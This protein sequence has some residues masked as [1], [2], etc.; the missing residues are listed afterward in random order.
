MLNLRLSPAP[1]LN[2]PPNVMKIKRGQFSTSL[3]LYSLH[4][5]KRTVRGF[6]IT[7]AGRGLYYSRRNLK[8]KR[9]IFL[10]SEI[11]TSLSSFCTFDWDNGQHCFW[12]PL[13]FYVL[14]IHAAWCEVNDV[15]ERISASIFGIVLEEDYPKYWDT[16]LWNMRSYTSAH[17]VLSIGL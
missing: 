17:C 13:R 16:L 4:L 15:S 10:S 9:K 3:K 8:T 6:A 7:S 14:W 11:W 1:P 12:W 5:H 2:C